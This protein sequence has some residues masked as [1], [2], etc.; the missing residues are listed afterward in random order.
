MLYLNK[1][2]LPLDEGRIGVEDR[3]FQFGDGVYEAIKV[4]NGT[5]L[6]WQ[7]HLRR[8]AGNLQALRME[9]ALDGH[10]LAAVLPRLVELSDLTDGLVYLQVT[11][12]AGPRDFFFPERLEPT[13]LAYARPHSFPGESDILSGIVAKLVDDFRWGRCDIKAITLLS[14]VLAKQTAREAGCQEAL[15]VGD[16]VVREGASSNF[17]GVLAGVLRTHPPDN[18]ILNGITRQTVLRLAAELGLTVVEEAVPLAELD[19]L[20][21]AFIA[22]T[23]NDV[24]PVV[25]FG[26]E[27]VADGRHGPVSLALSSAVRRE[28][29]ALAGLAMPRRLV[30]L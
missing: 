29:A 24:M 28:A 18:H 15:W 26:S 25:A 20:D 3:G 12:G 9:G 27:P 6:W 11:R 1:R 16:Q 30:R 10:D 13:V 8:L 5:M 2:L 7:E 4:L 19:R 17:F 23:T 21:E 14:A 22:S